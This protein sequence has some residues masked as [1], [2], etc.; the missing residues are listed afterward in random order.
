MG[1]SKPK[2]GLELAITLL[3][4][5][6]YLFTV[7]SDTP[8]PSTQIKL[9]MR[10][11]TDLQGGGNRGAAF[12][13]YISRVPGRLLSPRTFLPSTRGRRVCYETSCGVAKSGFHCDVIRS[14]HY[15]HV[16]LKRSGR[17]EQSAGVA[18][19]PPPPPHIFLL[20]IYL[21]VGLRANPEPSKSQLF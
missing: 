16:S 8:P 4:I 3:K 13:S 19:S 5:G 12:L 9:R 15:E 1:S 18:L 7:C 21:L 17:A 20:R 6:V 2:K 10:P 14:P 11:P